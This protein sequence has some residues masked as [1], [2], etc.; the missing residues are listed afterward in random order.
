MDYAG[1]IG[2]MDII[3]GLACVRI[4]WW[5]LFDKDGLPEDASGDGGPTTGPLRTDTRLSHDGAAASD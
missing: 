4:G 3:I 1:A 2:V 5:L